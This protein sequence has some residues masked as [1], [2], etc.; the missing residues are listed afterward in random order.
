MLSLYPTFQTGYYLLLVSHLSLCPGYFLLPLT[1]LFA[2]KHE[3]ILTAFQLDHMFVPLDPRSLIPSLID[4]ATSMP[5][6][7]T[8]TAQ[9]PP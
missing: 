3:P 1:L 2:L 7:V 8:Q 6:F 9:V 5:G 4:N